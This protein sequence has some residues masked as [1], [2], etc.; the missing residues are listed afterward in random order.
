M[1]L[2]SNRISARRD[3]RHGGHRKWWW[4]ALSV[5]IGLGFGLAVIVGDGYRNPAHIV[6]DRGLSTDADGV[7]GTVATTRGDGPFPDVKRPSEDG[8]LERTFPYFE[9]DKTVYRRA[10]EKI[11][12][13]TRGRDVAAKTDA[14]EWRSTGPLNIS[15]RIVDLAIDPRNTNRIYAA[16]ATGGVFVSETAGTS[17]TPIFDA[18]P[19]LSIGDIAL[20]PSNPDILYVGSGEPNGSINNYAGSGVFRSDD[21][22]ATWQSL[23]LERTTSIGR[24]IVHPQDPNTVFVAAI[25]SYFGPDADRGIYRS[26]DGGLS[27]DHVLSIN[28]STGVVDIAMRPGAPD[29]L[30][31]GAWQRVRRVTGSALY[32]RGSGVY[33]SMDGG[34]T[35]EKL[36]PDRGLPDPDTL[37]DSNGRARMGRVGITVSPASPL[38]V[39]AFFSDGSGYL[40]IFRS[41]DGGESWQDADPTRAMERKAN[42]GQ[43]PHPLL[44]NFS[45]YFGQIRVHPLDPDNVFVLDVQVVHSTDGGNLWVHKKG[46]HVDHHALA[47]DP[48]DPNT[49]YDGND[50]G[51]AVS[52][53]G[54][55]TWVELAPIPVTQLYR[56]TFDP[57][58]PERIYAGAQDQ[59]IVFT[60][61]GFADDWRQIPNSGDGMTVAVDPTDPNSLFGIVAQGKLFRMDGLAGTPFPILISDPGTGIPESD[62]RN[63]NTPF[64]IDPLDPDVFYYGT[65][66]LFRSLDRVRTGAPWTAISDD[67]SRGLG[68]EKIGTISTIALAPSNSDVIYTGTDDGNVWRSTDFGVSWTNISGGLP[69]RAVT[70]IEVSP[71]DPLHVYITFSG[72][73]FKDAEP[74]VFRSKDGGSDWT[75]IST[76]LPDLPI[77]TIVV[78]PMNPSTLFLGSDIGAFLSL[79]DGAHWAPFNPGL[80][81]V[82]IT[83]LVIEP[84]QRILIAGTFGR[85]TFVFPLGDLS[86]VTATESDPIVPVLLELKSVYPNPFSDRITFEVFISRPGVIG[87]EIYDA[88]GRRVRHFRVREVVPGANEILWDGHTDSGVSVSP[89][90]YIARIVQTAGDKRSVRSRTITRV[91]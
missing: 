20:A 36:G 82:T 14:A 64:A 30:Y 45:W 88:I 32:G 87:I 6:G 26:S 7:F 46:S 67:M 74:H 31:A 56:V 11:E 68:Y 38:T 84:L 33:R 73:L 65:N 40:G 58:N 47:F 71:I 25:G 29:V 77:N 51:V 39:Y 17:W 5:L 18:Q 80:P 4:Q 9:A 79:D 90:T 28:D 91:R 61:S 44:F 49:I 16:A 54:G 52:H 72:L 70:D 8:W 83:D 23:G 35:W 27:W 86:E 55:S 42:I 50:G 2:L 89:G 59:G 1:T 62:P 60:R 34:D 10:F 43:S 53:D 75:D 19:V 21:R 3:H 57:N 37:L 66:R 63:W 24:I 15:G 48:G 13:L 76:G 69:L 22:G 41:D 78:D 12:T 85:G 81:L